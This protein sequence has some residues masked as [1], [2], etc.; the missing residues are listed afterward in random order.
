MQYLL[1]NNN[2]S[3]SVAA[4]NN[5]KDSDYTAHTTTHGPKG[6]PATGDDAFAV[7]SFEAPPTCCIIYAHEEEERLKKCAY[8]D[9]LARQQ[10]EV[11][12]YN[13]NRLEK[14]LAQQQDASRMNNLNDRN[15]AVRML[16]HEAQSY[17]LRRCRSLGLRILP[18]FGRY[19]QGVADEV[20]DYLCPCSPD[21]GTVRA[22]AEVSRRLVW[23]FG[24]CANSSI[25]SIPARQPEDAMHDRQ[26]RMLDT[27]A[28]MRKAGTLFEA[29]R[30]MTPSGACVSAANTAK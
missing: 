28:R 19:W 16:L 4:E 7:S 13:A 18:S 30:A 2:N 29:T 26:Q 11:R 14:R 12:A 25:S 23:S 10:E 27:I 8:E 24:S 3:K 22:L 6:F 17:D 20:E 5:A 15:I 21:C 1:N 9:W